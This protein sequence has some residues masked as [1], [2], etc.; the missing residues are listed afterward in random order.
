MYIQGLFIIEFLMY[1]V[2]QILIM[3]KYSYIY[4]V[5]ITYRHVEFKCF[6]W[7]KPVVKNVCLIIWMSSQC[8]LTNEAPGPVFVYVIRHSIS[9]F[10]GTSKPV[11]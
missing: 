10:I 5:L 7:P 6:A 8:G 4:K 9:N 3:S 11:V 2:T 1:E